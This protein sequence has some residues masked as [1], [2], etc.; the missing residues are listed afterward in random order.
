M[1]D[2]VSNIGLPSSLIKTT[3]SDRINLP[4]RL[5]SPNITAFLIIIVGMILNEMIRG[6]Q[7]TVLMKDKILKLPLLEI[8][9]TIRQ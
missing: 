1:L 5:K 2:E 3:I 8:E 4:Q 9:A 7:N 6:E